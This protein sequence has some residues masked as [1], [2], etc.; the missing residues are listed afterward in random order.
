MSMGRRKTEKQRALFILAADLPQTA[1]RRKFNT[2]RN[3]SKD[4][5]VAPGGSSRVF[6]AGRSSVGDFR[7]LSA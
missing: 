2:A 3:W 7:N 1:G 5:S 6:V 4:Q